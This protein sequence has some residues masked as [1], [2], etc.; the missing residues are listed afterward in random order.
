MRNHLAPS[1]ESSV[2]YLAWY[3]ITHFCYGTLNALNHAVSNLWLSLE[4]HPCAF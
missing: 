3:N 1:G 2:F 4:L